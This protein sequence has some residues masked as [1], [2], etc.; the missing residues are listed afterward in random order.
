MCLIF[1]VLL[2]LIRIDLRK[3]QPGRASACS[4]SQGIK[5]VLN[6]GKSV[7]FFFINHLELNHTTRT[8]STFDL[9]SVQ[10]RLHCSYSSCQ[11][12]GAAAEAPPAAG[13]SGRGA[14]RAG[15]HTQRRD[16]DHR[17]EAGDGG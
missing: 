2:G 13:T 17:H 12:A 6:S 8:V 10:V 16:L 4:A 1:D 11:H 3:N 5:H 7:L 9:A 15:V 14:V